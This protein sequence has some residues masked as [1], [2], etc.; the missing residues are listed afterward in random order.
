MT[1]LVI[2][3]IAIIAGPVLAVQAQKWLDN[4]RASRERKLHVFR[5]LWLPGQL[6]CH[7]ATSRR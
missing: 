6:R 3:V 7:L 4:R 2:T 5:I 1:Q